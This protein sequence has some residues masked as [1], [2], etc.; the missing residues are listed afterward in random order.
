MSYD[1][2]LFDNDGVIIRNTD[3]EVMRRGVRNAFRTAG[4]DRPE[5][6]HVASLTDFSTVTVPE[7]CRI[8]YGY[9]LDPEGF[10]STREREVHAVQREEMRS[11]RKTLFEDV[12]ALETLDSLGTALGIVSNNQHDTVEF[13]IDHFE[14]DG[15]FGTFYGVEPTF[16]GIRRKKPDPYYLYR[17]MEDLGAEAVLYV[18]DKGTDVHAARAAGADAVYLRR[19]DDQSRAETFDRPPEFEVES[20]AE[21]VSIVSGERAATREP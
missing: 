10:W 3:G 12:D 5:P 19:S 15:R 4:I 7:V 14:L 21:L 11:A 2:V 9:G 8:C 20:L 6:D 16:D 1:T 18:G 13:M 17:A